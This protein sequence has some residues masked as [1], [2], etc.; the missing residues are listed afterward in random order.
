MTC[1]E[2]AQGFLIAFWQPSHIHNIVINLLHIHITFTKNYTKL[3]GKNENIFK[4]V[5]NVTMAI[6][7]SLEPNGLRM[8]SI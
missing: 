1:T 3:V 8:V 2:N 6:I 7:Q 5:N 4:M